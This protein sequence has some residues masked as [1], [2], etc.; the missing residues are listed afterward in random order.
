MLFFLVGATHLNQLSMYCKEQITE[1]QWALAFAIKADCVINI[2]AV[3]AFMSLGVDSVSGT[4]SKEVE[5]QPHASRDFSQSID[6][7]VLTI[8]IACWIAQTSIV[9]PIYAYTAQF[10]LAYRLA[11]FYSSKMAKCCLR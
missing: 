10:S 7:A 2:L 8:S 4:V 3:L 6:D 1:G 5:D 9:L 11:L